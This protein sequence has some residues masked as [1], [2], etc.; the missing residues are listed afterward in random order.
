MRKISLLLCVFTLF[1]ISAGYPKTSL[2]NLT[3]EEFHWLAGHPV[4]RVAP[5]PGFPP[6]E[7]FGEDG[8]IDGLSIDFLLLLSEKLDVKFDLVR[9]PVWSNV[10]E[11]IDNGEVDLLSAV[12]YSALLTNRL[13]FTMP[14]VILPGAIAAQ[15]G[16]T[17]MLDPEKLNGM[18]VAVVEN[19]YWHEYLKRNYPQIELLPVADIATG[20]RKVSY[21]MADCMVE[22]RESVSFYLKGDDF[23][24]LKIAGEMDVQ[25]K[26][27]FAVR[28]DWPLFQ[29]ILQKAMSSLSKEE[30]DEIM[31]EWLSFG[32][33]PIMHKEQWASI[34]VLVLG[35]GAFLFGTLMINRS[36]KRQVIQKT[37][38]LNIELAER[39]KAEEKLQQTRDELE[40]RV[41]ER[42]RELQ[43]LN[44]NLQEQIEERIR[45]EKKIE[46]DLNFR[47]KFIDAI[48][49]P[50]YYRDTERR[51]LFCNT[52]FL[53]V[54][55]MTREQIIGRNVQESLE[56]ANI[57]IELGEND[58][59]VW[60]DSLDNATM[61]A[62]TMF[63]DGKT[64]TILYNRSLIYNADGTPDGAIGAMLDITDRKS[65]E[66]ALRESEAKY[67]VLVEN[68]QEGVFIIDEGRFVFV[69]DAFARLAECTKEKLY[70]STVLDVISPEYRAEFMPL[71]DHK[72]EDV[73][74]AEIENFEFIGLTLSDQPK[75]KFIT[76]SSKMI[77]YNGKPAALGTIRDITESRRMQDALKNSEEQYRTLIENIQE[78][79]FILR[80]E[81]IEFA[82]QSFLK[83]VGFP[84][85][86]VL[87][88]SINDF[89][90]SED[91]PEN[92]F[93]RDKMCMRQ[94]FCEFFVSLKNQAGPKTTLHISSARIDYL[95]SE[96]FLGTVRDITE[97]RRATEELMHRD[98]VLEGVSHAMLELVTNPN[99]SEAIRKSLGSIGSSMEVDRVFLIQNDHDQ[100]GRTFMNLKFEW[101]SSSVQKIGDSRQLQQI[102]YDRLSPMWLGK[103]SK[104]EFIDGNVRDLPESDRELFG[105]FEVKSFLA[106]PI[107][108]KD[109]FWGLI[110]FNDCRKERVWSSSDESLL[111][112]IA[113][114]FGESISH[115]DAEMELIKLSQ[116]IE[117][118]P[119]CIAIFDLNGNFEYVNPKFLEI[120][121]NYFQ[122]KEGIKS[123]DTN[124]ISVEIKDVVLSGKVYHE[125]M[126][127]VDGEDKKWLDTYIYPIKNDSGEIMN[128]ASL[129]MDI[130]ERKR[131]E[132]RVRQ[133]VALQ[134]SILESAENVAI[135]SLDRNYK[136]ILFNKAHEEM[137]WKLWMMQPKIGISQLDW[138]KGIPKEY[139]A[140]KKGMDFVMSGKSVT[141]VSAFF[142]RKL[143]DGHSVFVPYEY[144]DKTD[145]CI[146]Y[147]N[148]ISPILT[149][150]GEIIGMTSF[151]I[152]ITERIRAENELRKAK[153][154]AE[155][156]TKAK[157]EFLANMSHEIRTPMN[158][159]IGMTELALTNDLDQKLA[160]YLSIIRSSSQSLLQ[161][162]NDILDFSKI[163]AGKLELETT[164]FNLSEILDQIIDI[165]RNRAV[166]KEI[167]MIISA[168][169]D[170][171]MM[172]MG[173]PLRISQILINLVSNAIKFTETGSVIIKVD[174]LEGQDHTARLKFSIQ[175]TGIGIAKE[176]VALLFESF[177]Q[178]DGST[179]RKFG[180]TGLGLAICR[181]LV[182]LMGGD[183]WVESEPG[184]GSTFIFTLTLEVQKESKSKGRVFPKEL[185][186]LHV[187]MVDDNE[188][189]RIVLSQM[190]NSF[191]FAVTAVPGGNEAEK[192][193]ASR[194]DGK[195]KDQ[196]G[197]LMIDWK[198]PDR[199]GIEVA[200]S[201]KSREEWKDI[202]VILMTAFGSVREIN[203][204]K[205]V[206]VNAFL[207][208]P[209]K[210]SQLFDIII[211]LFSGGKDSMRER[212]TEIIT[213]QSLNRSFVRGAH[214]L[215]VEDN[216][217]N[218]KVAV[219]I[220]SQA[221]VNVEVANNG[222]EAL[223][224]L[225]HKAYD[226]ILMDVQMPE[227]DGFEATRRIRQDLRMIQVPIIAMTANAMK[228][229][230]E[231][232]LEAGMNDY[233]S[234]PIHIDELF[235]VLKKWVEPGAVP[236]EKYPPVNKEAGKDTLPDEID[237]LDI[238]GAM[239]RLE[240][241]K[242]LYLELLHDFIG[243]NKDFMARIR[244]AID[245]HEKETAHR[246]AHTIKGVSGAIG[247]SDL[248]LAA[249]ELDEALKT[250]EHDSFAALLADT[251]NELERVTH[252]I[253][254]FLKSSKKKSGKREAVPRNIENRKPEIVLLKKLLQKG[255]LEAEDVIKKIEGDFL[256]SALG[257]LFARMKKHVSN[258]RFD[259]A[260]K[261]AAEI[262]IKMGI[263]WSSENE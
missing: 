214:F 136:Y 24:G 193:L 184:K 6:I 192:E 256:N 145:V 195:A 53:D 189:T 142:E 190:L 239:K 171:P 222:I 263:E 58:S 137:C 161:I 44:L 216:R 61:E 175:D 99:F 91:G 126:T 118:S 35:I 101:V 68:L 104:G 141:E 110:A 79:V 253:E 217:I 240:N 144:S 117:Y 54:L 113:G 233:I 31:E 213:R 262:G 100:S 121:E 135:A 81:K 80:E 125:E 153:E 13:L 165:F 155:A 258:Y 226:A 230:R 66:A 210:Q 37:K 130:S 149:D 12:S 238:S 154:E 160:E 3:A 119:S 178:A 59:S 257:D 188:A 225:K 197:L 85:E 183:I 246:L 60:D 105:M 205:D 163:E 168:D 211:D 151:A 150:E 159:I 212:Q 114:A 112:A 187:L 249:R 182:E 236:I 254:K 108:I 259:D 5:N 83:M 87:G 169:K 199:N 41:Q 55:G 70:A 191:G 4:I 96:A 65:A 103:L 43:E 223:D 8:D 29:G 42:T 203:E 220:L 177:T 9:V 143:P 106:V 202:P 152:D 27:G 134:K 95:G 221:G 166:E 156:A 181:S 97:K 11:S 234:K 19:G 40:I 21:G 77:T 46:A 115:H 88:K 20:L 207:F 51:F 243:E 33:P 140:N 120:S 173:D 22:N 129:Q 228:G 146:Y 116:V 10:I 260:E 2:T 76:M 38:Q 52:A 235:S 157:S 89:V 209:I 50:I 71:N 162:I 18:K 219:E 98:M 94:G 17:E 206:G 237:G 131:A 245:G 36:L 74:G 47:Q 34:L 92:V 224:A 57:K 62:E 251:G 127:F 16:V 138:L 218:Q 64:H 185:S 45:I 196:F 232:C 75:R 186:N 200:K 56:A 261:I 109:Y 179:T 194:A 231:K 148:I 67:R 78:G 32:P 7:W 122:G 215:L 72:S 23:S 250:W 255:E 63:R 252:S 86:D 14:Y 123:I 124:D 15:G 198:M 93:T 28:K 69:N 133:F 227:M 107:R 26:Y 242:E 30:R 241:N 248:Y 90:N 247:A 84:R 170:V 158:A 180:G 132:E 82:N 201:I 39:I 25:A 102:A 147:E 204:A 164:E 174:S 229:D 172:L 128:I 139:E 244:S 167:E 48:P 176:K 49:I 1:I 208:K 73:L 111:T